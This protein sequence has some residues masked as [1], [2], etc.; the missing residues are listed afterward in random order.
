MKR[1]INILSVVLLS[2]YSFNGLTISK[3]VKTYSFEIM[4]S[5]KIS[6]YGRRVRGVFQK[7]LREKLDDTGRTFVNNNGDIKFKCEIEDYKTKILKDNS[8][9]AV[10][11][12]S[13]NVTYSNRINDSHDMDNEKLEAAIDIMEN[14][15]NN[16]DDNIKVLVDKFCEILFDKTVRA[17]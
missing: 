9:K 3:D 13:M 11:I 2:N 7:K 4:E 17:W 6:D 15:V 8:D 12:L 16:T 1:V 10:A 14:Q 5:A